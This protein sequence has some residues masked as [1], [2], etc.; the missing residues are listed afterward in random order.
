MDCPIW[1]QVPLFTVYPFKL[2]GIGA[3]SFANFTVF[4]SVSN[5]IPSIEAPITE[6]VYKLLAES[7]YAYFVGL[8]K[9]SNYLKRLG[10][11]TAG[12]SILSL[13]DPNH[14]K[15]TNVGFAKIITGTYSFSQNLGNQWFTVLATTIQVT[16]GKAVLLASGGINGRY[17]G[18]E[19]KVCIGNGQLSIPKIVS[20]YPPL[21]GMECYSPPLSKIIDEGVHTI[22]IGVSGDNVSTIQARATIVVANVDAN[23]ISN[24]DNWSI[25]LVDPTSYV[26]EDKLPFGKC[27]RKETAT[28]SLTVEVTGPFLGFVFPLN[29]SSND[30]YGSVYI[31][32]NAVPIFQ[33]RVVEDDISPTHALAIAVG[34]KPMKIE[35]RQPSMHQSLCFHNLL[36]MIKRVTT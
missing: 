28:D 22:A 33:G 29:N 23:L 30:T 20:S 18:R 12:T 19:A 11:G 15:A 27:I 1:L 8:S 13:N 4:Q 7:K 16:G 32:Y 36:P 21:D 35:V 6:W 25:R 24:A 14:Q 5:D 31:N 10:L 17:G 26:Y 34:D 9:M 2:V 3:A